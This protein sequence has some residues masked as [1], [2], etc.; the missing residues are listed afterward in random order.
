MHDRNA[1][2]SGLRIHILFYSIIADQVGTRAEVRVVACGST[3]DELLWALAAEHPALEQYL[4]DR[5]K[6]AQH[7]L[8]LFRNGRVA[9]NAVEP[10]ADG[11][12]IR[13]FPVISG[14]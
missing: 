8:R 2:P 1:R 5:D 12:T 14:G 10:L 6:V 4:G 9:L 11:D 3:I 7:G 13:I